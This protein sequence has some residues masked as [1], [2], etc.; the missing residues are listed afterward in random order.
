MLA[1]DDA[2]NVNRVSVPFNGN[3]LSHERLNTVETLHHCELK[4]YPPDACLSPA[5]LSRMHGEHISIQLRELNHLVVQLRNFYDPVVPQTKSF[6]EGVEVCVLE[7]NGSFSNWTVRRSRRNLGDSL[8]L[9]DPVSFYL[10]R[11]SP[12]TQSG[13]RQRCLPIQ[14][15]LGKSPF[16]RMEHAIGFPFRL[17]LGDALQVGDVSRVSYIAIDRAVVAAAP[18]RIRT[19]WYVTGCFALWS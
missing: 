13:W 14:L 18:T 3:L 5:Q 4:G 8:A 6:R 15:R 9:V 17:R 7:F 1:V 16:D 2:T 11:R 10:Q 12:S 19:F